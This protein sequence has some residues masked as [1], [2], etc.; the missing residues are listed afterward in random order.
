MIPT[1]VL[2][3]FFLEIFNDPLVTGPSFDY[4]YYLQDRICDGCGNQCPIRSLIEIRE[5]PKLSYLILWGGAF[6]LLYFIV[7]FR[8]FVELASYFRLQTDYNWA[9]FYVP[10]DSRVP[11]VLSCVYCMSNYLPVLSS[12]ASDAYINIGLFIIL[13]SVSLFFMPSCFPFLVVGTCLWQILQKYRMGGG[14]RLVLF[15]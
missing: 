2:T 13:I 7:V 11:Y 12:Q 15:H 4:L 9:D 14:R 10:V 5:I 6:R 8:Y 3:S 1:S